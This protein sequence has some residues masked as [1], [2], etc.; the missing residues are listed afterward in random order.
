MML[1][2]SR[3]TLILCFF[4]VSKPPSAYMYDATTK[5]SKKCFSSCDGN[6][7]FSHDLIFVEVSEWDD[8]VWFI[9][10]SVCKLFGSL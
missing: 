5:W 6:S 7:G 3:H 10:F 4:C 8:I 1:F 2:G 9:I